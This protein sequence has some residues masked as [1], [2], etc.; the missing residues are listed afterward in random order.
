MSTMAGTPKVRRGTPICCVGRKVREA[1]HERIPSA[2]RR[3][4]C[5]FWAHVGGPGFQIRLGL[6]GRVIRGR[7]FGLCANTRRDRHRWCIL[8]HLRAKLILRSSRALAGSVATNALGSEPSSR[9]LSADVRFQM[10]NG[11]CRSPH[12]QMSTRSAMLKASSS[13][14]PRYRTVLS[15]FVWPISN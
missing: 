12:A 6:T 3:A 13:S 7:F 9:K 14:T 5:S 15:T 11:G 10:A 1:H 2:A 8:R 4:P